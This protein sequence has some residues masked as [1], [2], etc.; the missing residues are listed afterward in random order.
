ME[1]LSDKIILKNRENFLKNQ[2]SKINDEKFQMVRTRRTGNRRGEGGPTKHVA[3]RFGV[4]QGNA[5]KILV[6]KTAIAWLNLI[7]LLDGPRPFH[8]RF[9]D[10]GAV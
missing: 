7:F 8:G 5:G 1:N 9:Q 2:A 10:E 3:L 4:L 6:L